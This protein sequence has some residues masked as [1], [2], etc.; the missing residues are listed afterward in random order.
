MRSS[1][2][3]VTANDDVALLSRSSISSPHNCQS[4]FVAQCKG[5]RHAAVHGGCE[6]E[7]DAAE[8]REYG[9]DDVVDDARVRRAPVELI[10]TR[11]GD[12][13][14]APDDACHD[15]YDPH[16]R[17]CQPGA[18][19]AIGHLGEGGTSETITST[20]DKSRKGVH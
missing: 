4:L 11:D 3:P 12:A 15:E 5:V 16:R 6:R 14:S 1:D 7:C 10:Y 18:F 20:R 17:A 9:G 2:R 8:K 19:R 13:T